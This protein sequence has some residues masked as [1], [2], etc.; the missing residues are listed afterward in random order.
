MEGLCMISQKKRVLF[1]LFVL[2]ALLAPLASPAMSD[3]MRQRMFGPPAPQAPAGLRE[4]AREARLAAQQ[5]EKELLK[6]ISQTGGATIAT[7]NRAREA[8]NAQQWLDWEVARQAAKAKQQAYTEARVQANIQKFVPNQP[9]EQRR[10]ADRVYRRW[11]ATGPMFTRDAPEYTAQQQADRARDIEIMRLEDLVARG[12]E[13]EKA[14]RDPVA[15][16]R[17][18]KLADNYLK[19]YQSYNNYGSRLPLWWRKWRYE[20]AEEAI[21]EDRRETRRVYKAIEEAQDAENELQK[22]KRER[23]EEQQLK[24]LKNKI[25]SGQGLDPVQQDAWN[26]LQKKEGKK[27][28]VAPVS[29]T[30]AALPM[31]VAQ[32]EKPE[33]LTLDEIK[34]L[35]KKASV[36]AQEMFRAQRALEDAQMAG[37]T[38][39]GG[40]EADLREK[41]A[42]FHPLIDSETIAIANYLEE[43][44]RTSVPVPVITP[45]EPA[46]GLKSQIAELEKQET[47]AQDR[48]AVTQKA[49]QEMR[50]SPTSSREELDDAK[51]ALDDAKEQVGVVFNELRAARK[52]AGEGI[53]TLSP[54]FKKKLEEQQARF[55][56]DYIER[57]KAAD[58]ERQRIAGLTE[59]QKLQ[60][61]QARLKAE[62]AV[63]KAA[64]GEREL[65]PQER[66]RLQEYPTLVEGYEEMIKDERAR[67]AEKA[68]QAGTISGRLKS[69]L[70]GSK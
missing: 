62:L 52:A 38:D 17:R 33:V 53:G 41:T 61:S 21:E 27:G 14:W 45:I 60:E 7:S 2:S 39:L 64:K 12:P 49:Y 6:E 28:V 56:Q 68:Q 40:L 31:P 47:A 44:K 57:A 58:A 19:A 18:D 43:R 9:Y 15:Q 22:L 59:L 8:R 29:A 30:P 66:Y 67:E 24:F 42:R 1:K 48:L 51:A 35:Q 37:E 70:F 34:A 50:W 10:E 13:I 63:L 3:Y 23:L 54:E 4:Q 25:A 16:A 26:R 36:A 20:R 32:P 65:I 5:A 69:G 55:T 11:S 46:A